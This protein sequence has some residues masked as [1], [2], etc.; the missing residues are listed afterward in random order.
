MPLPV[1][2]RDSFRQHLE[3]LGIGRG[4]RIAVHS[5]LTAFGEIEGGAAMIA[6]VLVETVGEDGTV[7][8]PTYVLGAPAD[9]IYDPTTTPSRKVGLLPE[10]I[11]QRPGARRSL[12]PIH[13]HAAIGAEAAVVE[14]PDGRTS[15]GP[16]SDF[17]ALHD[18]GFD[19]VLLG[20]R[21][22]EGAT[23]L[24][25]L[26]VLAEV[27][28]REWITLHRR[29]RRRD[30]READMEVRY[31]AQRT[32]MPPSDF[33]GVGPLLAELG[34]DRRVRCPLGMSHAVSLDALHRA[35]LDCLSRDPWAWAGKQQDADS[36][37]AG[38]GVS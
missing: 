25:H 20:C 18:A 11:R 6:D 37:L 34:L 10:E 23:Y 9:E 30:G 15:L 13:N 16:G 35:G 1:T 17:E 8:V 38:A 32:G 22:Q 4:A 31:Y 12:C 5:R 14:R 7:V 29:I 3:A 26:E 28:Y 36:A 21:Y 27:P 2:T 19:L 33:S 24:H